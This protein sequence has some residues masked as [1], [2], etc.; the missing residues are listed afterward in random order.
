MCQNIGDQ[1]LTCL[2]KYIFDKYDFKCNYGKYG[3]FG[4]GINSL[5]RKWTG[6]SLKDN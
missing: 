5:V 6:I 4:K 1:N 2:H 3:F